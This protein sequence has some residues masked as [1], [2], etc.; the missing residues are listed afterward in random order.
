M[1][2]IKSEN[3]AGG[4]DVHE[5]YANFKTWVWTLL[6]RHEDVRLVKFTETDFIV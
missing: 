5:T 6:F 2:Q 3:K 4:T 1:S